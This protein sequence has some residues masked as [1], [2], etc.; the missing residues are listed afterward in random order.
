MTPAVH[1]DEWPSARCSHQIKD[2]YCTTTGLISGLCF[3]RLKWKS[4]P[5]LHSHFS[6]LKASCTD[7]SSLQLHLSAYWDIHFHSQ[8]LQRPTINTDTSS[9]D[10]THT[11]A[12]DFSAHHSLLTANPKGAAYTQASYTAWVVFTS[13]QGFETPSVCRDHQH[14]VQKKRSPKTQ[15]TTSSS[16]PPQGIA[17]KSHILS[18][19]LGSFLPRHQRNN[20]RRILR[21]DTP[22]PKARAIGTSYWMHVKSH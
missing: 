15:P 5:C 10:H 9:A 2:K 12:H 20:N 17:R 22:P 14:L 4:Y 19:E 7:I 13:I 21:K 11:R 18:Q 3:A 16:S 8:H 6:E 1:R